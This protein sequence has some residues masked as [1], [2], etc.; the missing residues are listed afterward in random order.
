MTSK[1]LVIAMQE[2][3]YFIANHKIK[4]FDLCVEDLTFLY[5]DNLYPV[6]SI[7]LNEMFLGKQTLKFGYKVS[8]V[9]VKNN[10][11]LCC[12]RNNN[13]PV[14]TI[15]ISFNEHVMIWDL[16]KNAEVVS[17]LNIVCFNGAE[18]YINTGF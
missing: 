9:S 7:R 17:L 13:Q 6:S 11:R 14:D 12:M 8:K 2:K 18:E 10:E 1:F 16:F 15:Q 4:E 5:R 3:I